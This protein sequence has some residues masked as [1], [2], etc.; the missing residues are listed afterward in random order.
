MSHDRIAAVYDLGVIPAFVEHT[1]IDTKD[2]T[3][4]NGTGHSAFIRAD[5]HKM[6]A[7]DFH[8]RHMFTQRFNKLVS[9]LD[10]IKTA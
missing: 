1:Y 8:I 4:V 9:R 2:S 3:I 5:D 6:I 7:V 10:V